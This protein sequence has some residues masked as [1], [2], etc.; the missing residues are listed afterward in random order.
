MTK[1]L[2]SSLELT[3]LIIGFLLTDLKIALITLQ[4]ENFKKHLMTKSHILLRELTI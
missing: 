1:I 4:I 3:T 2:L